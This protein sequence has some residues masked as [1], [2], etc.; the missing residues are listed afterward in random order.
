MLGGLARWL[1]ILGYEA[2]YDSTIDDASLLRIAREKDMILLTRDEELHNRAKAKN[3]SSMLVMGETEEERLAQL[4]R[5]LGISL[6]IDRARTRCPECGSELQQASR[7][8]VASDVPSQSLKIY[9]QYWKCGNLECA[10]VYW[11]GSHWKQIHHTLLEARRM[12]E[13]ARA[14]AGC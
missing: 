1:R 12:A 6:R 7:Q 13:A 9:N 14:K 11:H 10:K 8:A 3:L 5:T 4:A 2:D